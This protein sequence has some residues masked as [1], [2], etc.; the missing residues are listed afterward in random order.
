MG[1]ICLVFRVPLD[2]VELDEA[3][4]SDAEAWARL[5]PDNPIIAV[6]ILELNHVAVV[7]AIRCF[8]LSGLTLARREKSQDY[9]GVSN[10][11]SYLGS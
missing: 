3:T 7:N 2:T 10:E 6:G 1:N 9:I 4:W 5:D 11:C 8:C